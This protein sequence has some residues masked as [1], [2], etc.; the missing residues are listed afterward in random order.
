MADAGT[1]P[2]FATVYLGDSLALAA[3][4]LLVHSRNVEVLQTYRTLPVY[5]PEEALVHVEP[6]ELPPGWASGAR[7]TTRAIGTGGSRMVDPLHC[8]CRAW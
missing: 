2:G 7:A 6:G 1:V 8:R 5:I 4:E 3:M